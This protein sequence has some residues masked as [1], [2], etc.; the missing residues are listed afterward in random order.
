MIARGYFPPGLTQEQYFARTHIHYGHPEE[1]VRSLRADLVLPHAT[2]LIVQAHPGYPTPQQFI[3]ALE[4]I[5][6]EVAPA[7]G[8]RPPA[9]SSAPPLRAGAGA[10]G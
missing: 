3:R 10:D 2:E 7:L 6:N 9:A 4:R 1:V 5:A 8:W